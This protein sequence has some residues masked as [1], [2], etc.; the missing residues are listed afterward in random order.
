MGSAECGVGSAECGSG[1]VG[2]AVGRVR[3]G[4]AE[5]GVRNAEWGV[6]ME[7]GMRNA[8]WVLPSPSRKLV[9]EMIANSERQPPPKH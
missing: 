7:C 1:G 9:Y 4:N 2:N 5:C 3:M 8:G 6:R